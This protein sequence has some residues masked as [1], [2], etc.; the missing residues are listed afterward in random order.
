MS[1]SATGPER[2]RGGAAKASRPPSRFT[3][4]QARTA[5][6][7]QHA[8]LLRDAAGLQP[9]VR[10]S[11]RGM[12]GEGE[13]LVGGEDADAVVGLGM[14]GRQQEGGLGEVGPVGELL[15]LLRAEA[16]G[17]NNHR[18]RVAPVGL[19]R[20]HVHLGERTT[21]AGGG[22]VLAHRRRLSPGAARPDKRP[23]LCQTSVMA[24]N[25]TQATGA[26]VEEFL[27]AV[28]HPVRHRDGCGCWR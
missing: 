25:K 6:L 18:E 26:S 8:V 10:R 24:E 27:A 11:Q 1:A 19:V 15:H 17:I 3:A 13:L 16:V 28:E 20:E 7:D 23:R 9:G 21:A 22:R 2:V 5:F 14:G 12:A 4:D